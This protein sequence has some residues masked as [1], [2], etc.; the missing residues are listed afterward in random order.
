MATSREQLQA[1]GQLAENWDGYGAAAPRAEAIE[2]AQAFIGLIETVRPP[3]AGRW[4]LSVSPTRMGGVLIE[5]E[6]ERR[7]HEVELDPDG[8]ISFLHLNKATQQVETRK[9]SPGQPA[10]VHPGL[11]GELQDLLAA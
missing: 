8:S 11:L 6:D 1:M 9:F 4:Q 10:V 2:L 3:Q 5:W 7:Q